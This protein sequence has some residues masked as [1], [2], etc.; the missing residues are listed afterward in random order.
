MKQRVEKLLALP[1]ISDDEK[2]E[3]TILFNARQKTLSAYNEDNTAARKKDYDAAKEG[4]QQMVDTLYGRLVE[5]NRLYENIKAMLDDLQAQGYKVSQGKL[6]GDAKAGH[7][8]LDADRS[9]SKQ[10]FADWCANPKGGLDIISVAEAAEEKASADLKRL[11][12]REKELDV[13][14]KEENLKQKQ[15]AN[16]KEDAKWILK[17]DA[18]LQMA[19]Q[20][21]ILKDAL[22][23]HVTMGESKLILAAGGK[24]EKSP[25]FSA[26]LK[27]VL[28]TAFN[29]IATSGRLEVL[30]ESID[31][32]ADDD[33]A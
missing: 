10:G 19:G 7:L 26:M 27:A 21:G 12:Q 14:N 9:I 32:D 18:Y 13:A 15:M 23:H 8:R 33:H 17:A 5:S 31:D 1:T 22:D 11:A 24:L 3:L 25:E 2:A 16:R 30:F 4:L 20:L 6:Y 28:T 29:E